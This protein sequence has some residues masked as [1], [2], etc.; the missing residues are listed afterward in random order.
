MEEHYYFVVSL[1][2]ITSENEKYVPKYINSSKGKR[3]LREQPAV[4][5]AI[6]RTSC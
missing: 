1:Y 5:G 2:Q 3:T 4:L 6:I